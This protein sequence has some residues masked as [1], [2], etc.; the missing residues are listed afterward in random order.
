M[1]DEEKCGMAQNRLMLIVNPNAGRKRG[2]RLAPKVIGWLREGGFNCRLS[3]T[4]KR[5][6]GTRFAQR[7][8]GEYDVVVCMGGDGTL[9]EV[10]NGILKGGHNVSLGYIP[11]GSTN[12]FAR[13]LNIS[14]DP[15]IA[16]NDF[17]KGHTVQRD[18][19]KYCDRYF[20]YVA[21]FGAFT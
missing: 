3:I 4:K 5:G 8:G 11:A 18:T 21:S 7:H 2:K 16:V 17:I 1:T 9:N 6:D 15:K 10:I 12:D 20:S 19:G 14:K 13:S